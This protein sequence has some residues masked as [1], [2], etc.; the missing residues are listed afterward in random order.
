MAPTV[1]P[2]EGSAHLGLVLNMFDPPPCTMGYEATPRRAGNQVADTPVNA[3][4]YCAAPDSGPVD[5]RGRRSALLPA[6]ARRSSRAA[7]GSAARRDRRRRSPAAPPS[8]A[9]HCRC[10]SLAQILL[11]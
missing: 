1:V 9:R 10:S 11:P 7:H 8:R 6:A 4:A 2:G 3:Q 5:V